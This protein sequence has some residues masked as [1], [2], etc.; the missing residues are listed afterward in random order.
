MTASIAIAATQPS[1]P[2][3]TGSQR[4]FPLMQTSLGLFKF[5]QEFRPIAA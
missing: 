2:A 4:A 5:R 3:N 1:L